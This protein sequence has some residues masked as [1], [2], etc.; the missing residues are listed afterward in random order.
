MPVE[1]EVIANNCELAS[2]VLD[3]GIKSYAAMRDLEP[4]YSFTCAENA[5][6][7]IS[8]WQFFLSIYA[9]VLIPAV[10]GWAVLY[11][12]GA[13]TDKFF[14]WGIGSVLFPIIMPLVALMKFGEIFAIPV[15]ENAAGQPSAE[16]R[17]TY[18]DD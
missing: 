18:A 11:R 9:V 7:T 8:A 4:S 17:R 1:F 3:A 2:Q 6:P 14:M 16:K 5:R 13:R 15:A 12:K 10:I